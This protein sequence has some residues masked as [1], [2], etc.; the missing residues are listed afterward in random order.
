MTF[1]DGPRRFAILICVGCTR[2]KR[3]RIAFVRGAFLDPV[4]WA[5]ATT[6]NVWQAACSLADQYDVGWRDEDRYWLMLQCLAELT[7]A[8]REKR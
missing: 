7:V 1:A 2:T 8:R 6:D 3:K 4:E 5:T